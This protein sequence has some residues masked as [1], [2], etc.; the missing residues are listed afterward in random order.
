MSR[1]LIFVRLLSIRLGGYYL[2]EFCFFFVE[3][4]L[5]QVG[6]RRFKMLKCI[7]VVAFKVTELRCVKVVVF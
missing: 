3:R 1:Q 4:S 2:F 7:E 6:G 5:G